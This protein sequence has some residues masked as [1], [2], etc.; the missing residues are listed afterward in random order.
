L[1]HHASAS[2]AK[3]QPDAHL[4]LTG[5]PAR[6]HHVRDV[7]ARREHDEEKGDGNRHEHRDGLAVERHRRSLRNE[8]QKSVEQVTPP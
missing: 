2:G 4:A 1:L 3:R 5:H 6:Q 7:R 8:L